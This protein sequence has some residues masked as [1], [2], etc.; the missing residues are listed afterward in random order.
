MLDLQ[1]GHHEILTDKF[2]YSFN[3]A[4]GYEIKFIKGSP[5]FIKQNILLNELVFSE[6]YPNPSNGVINLAL[7]TPAF[8]NAQNGHFNLFDLS[9]QLVL[10]QDILLNSGYQEIQLSMT[11]NGLSNGLYLL[12]IEI[13]HNSVQLLENITK[14]VFLKRSE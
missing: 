13:S 3:Y 7:N 1:T 8:E 2:N 5:E 9:G 6:I 14:K 11:E 4:E 10:S 12:E